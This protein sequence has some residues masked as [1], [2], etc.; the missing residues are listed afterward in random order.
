M[1]QRLKQ[2]GHRFAKVV[3]DYSQ[4]ELKKKK[5]ATQPDC[6]PSE[7]GNTTDQQE[8]MNLHLRM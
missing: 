2:D 6:V 1:R 7:S 3:H 4:R 8:I 5:R